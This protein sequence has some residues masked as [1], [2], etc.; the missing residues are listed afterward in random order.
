MKYEKLTY[1]EEEYTTQNKIESILKKEGL[2]WLIDSEF[3]NADIEVKNNTVIWN[4]GNYLYGDWYYGI[5]KGGTFHGKWLNGIFEEG[6]F[7]GDWV[8]GIKNDE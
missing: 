5:W 8:S 4:E 6:K 3:E 2:Y 1:Y 7:K